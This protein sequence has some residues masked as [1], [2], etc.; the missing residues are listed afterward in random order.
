MMGVHDNPSRLDKGGDLAI[1]A[2]KLI[3]KLLLSACLMPGT[4]YISNLP[5]LY[6]SLRGRFQ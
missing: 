3:L 4:F 1:I 6:P 2:S 5:T